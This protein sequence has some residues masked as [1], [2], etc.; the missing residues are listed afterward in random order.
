MLSECKK[1]AELI[2]E[3]LNDELNEEIK[4]NFENHINQCQACKD[5]LQFAKA[6][7]KAV[8]ESKLPD[9]PEDFIVR[10]HTAIDKEKIIELPQ[11]KTKQIIFARRWQSGIAACLIVAAFLGINM[12]ELSD[13]LFSNSDN[14]NEIVLNTAEDDITKD[15]IKVYES[16]NTS[17][18]VPPEEKKK[19]YKKDIPNKIENMKKPDENINEELPRATAAVPTV[20]PV[21]RTEENI[22]KISESISNSET[23]HKE[24]VSEHSS[25]THDIQEENSVSADEPAGV[26]V[27]SDDPDDEILPERKSI[28]RDGGNS[29][30]AADNRNTI[31]MRTGATSDGILKIQ[32]DRL[33]EA[34]NI[35]MHYGS[36]ENGILGMTAE[37]YSEYLKKLDAEE[38]EYINLAIS[39]D[40]VRFEIT[41]I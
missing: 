36:C 31:E 23:E 2:D 4:K 28:S 8:K 14:K 3:Y 34:K 22:E 6:I 12:V 21:K 26:A 19:K 24:E 41:E 18:T 16:G 38:I 37:K 27:M 17:E 20:P 7:Q 15:D 32:S 13:G 10:V 39:G 25:E 5:E 40:A 11:K 29:R 30:I 9:A 35:A 33:S 1:I